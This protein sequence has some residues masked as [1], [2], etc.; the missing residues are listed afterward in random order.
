[1][2]GHNAC[3]VYEEDTF[4]IQLKH[5]RKTVYLGTQRFLPKSHSYRRLQKLFNGSTGEGSSPKVLIGKGIY[6]S[7]NHL[8]PIYG[9]E[10]QNT[11]EKNVWKKRS[12][13]LSPI[14]K[15]FVCETLS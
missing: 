15:M 5:E 6:Q 13:F 9:K 2:K 12:F 14:L 1:M 4:S 3:P 11:V 8:R 10:N 7:V